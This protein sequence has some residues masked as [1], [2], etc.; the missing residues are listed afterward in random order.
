MVAAHSSQEPSKS[1]LPSNDLV[2]CFVTEVT[3][4]TDTAFMGGPPL[5]SSWDPGG[6][7][8]PVGEACIAFGGNWMELEEIGD[9]FNLPSFSQ[10]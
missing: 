8:H 6:I 10:V 3:E 9:V 4:V 5:V 2:P 1:F 7:C